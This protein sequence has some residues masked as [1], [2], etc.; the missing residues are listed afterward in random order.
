MATKYTKEQLKKMYDGLPE[1]LKEAI[2]SQESAESIFNACTDQGLQNDQIPL[3]AHLAGK[4]LMG[5][6]PPDE[7][8]EE[9]EKELKMKEGEAKELGRTIN[10]LVFYPVKELL[11]ELNRIAPIKEEGE[12]IKEIKKELTPGPEKPKEEEAPSSEPDTYRESIN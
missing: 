4:V 12:E 11:A 8:Q 10:K 9:V 6:L 7:F 1:E 3:V 2:Y 5:I